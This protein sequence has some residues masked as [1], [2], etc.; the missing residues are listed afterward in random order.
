VI[1]KEKTRNRV[2]VRESHNL[3]Q[4]QGGLQEGAV[5]TREDKTIARNLT[6]T[7]REKRS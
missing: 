4:Y 1:D 6:L 7:G 2:M 5:D 3:D